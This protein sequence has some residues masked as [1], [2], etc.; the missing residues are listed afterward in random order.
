MEDSKR[1]KTSKSKESK[2]AHREHGAS[3]NS[4]RSERRKGRKEH[5]ASTT[6]ERSEKRKGRKKKGGDGLV[7]TDADFAALESSSNETAYASARSS[8]VSEKNAAHHGTGADDA[9]AMAKG[10]GMVPVAEDGGDIEMAGMVF[11]AETEY[12]PNVEAD[13]EVMEAMAQQGDIDE[14]GGITAFVAETLLIGGDDVGVI[15]TDEEIE[16]EEKRKYTKRFVGIVCCLVVVIVAIAVPTTLKLAFAGRREVIVVIT[17]EPTST[18]SLMPSLSPSSAPSTVRY[19]EVIDKL[20]QDRIVPGLVTAEGK[21]VLAPLSS[22]EDLTKEGSPQNLAA[23]WIS[24]GDGMMMELTDPGFEQRY[25]MALFYYATDGSLW[26]NSN[27]W[28]S[29][30]SE[31]FWYGIEGSSNGCNDGCTLSLNSEDYSKVCRLKFGESN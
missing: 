5:A 10:S 6:S 25:V 26:I 1:K 23:R 19:T 16:V 22:R 14:A 27:G 29:E 8:R 28:L 21:A 11:D 31:C 7:G 17:E 18:P 4:E 2:K 30:D 20:S 24:D 13:S 15:R 3:T 9:D 12:Y